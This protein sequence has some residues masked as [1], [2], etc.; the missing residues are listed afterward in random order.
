M[1][2]AV[3]STIWVV[4]F[5]IVMMKHRVLGVPQD[6]LDAYG[7]VSEQVAK[8][9]AE[10]ARTVGQTTYAVFTTGIAGPA[11]VLEKAC[12]SCVVWCYWSI[13]AQWPIKLILIAN[14][15]DI[16]QSAAELAL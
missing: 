15:E 11:V 10:G 8:A 2:V 12:W 9:M 5:R 16:R 1:S 7:A 4:S 14:R 6:M 13:W 3:V